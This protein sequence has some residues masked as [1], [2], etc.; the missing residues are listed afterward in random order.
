MPPELSPALLH[1]ELGRAYLDWIDTAFA[2]NDSGVMKER[3]SLLGERGKLVADVYF[4]AIKK[5]QAG[6]SFA[7]VVAEIGL[8]EE[9]GQLLEKA[10]LPPGGTLYPHQVRAIQEF[11]TNG[12]CPIVV[13]GTGSGKTE[14]FLLPLIASILLEHQKAGVAAPPINRWWQENGIRQAG[15]PRAKAHNGHS[16]TMRALI[17]YPTNA[18]VEDQVSRLRRAVRQLVDPS[19]GAPLVWFGR[20]TGEQVDEKGNRPPGDKGDRA[21]EN[22]LKVKLR[23]YERD[24]AEAEQRA[25][26]SPELRS[27]LDY[28]PNPLSGELLSRLDIREAPPD[29]LVTNHSMLNVMLMRN[30][31]DSVFESTRDWLKEDSTHKFTLIVDELHLHRGSAGAEVGLVIRNLLR[32]IGLRSDSSQF[33]VIATS[34]SLGGTDETKTFARRFFGVS[35]SRFEVVDGAPI[36]LV[37]P[38]KLLANNVIDLVKGNQVSGESIAAYVELAGQLPSETIASS[39]STAVMSDRDLAGKLFPGAPSGI[40][41][42]AFE[43]LL[44]LATNEHANKLD[45]YESA[46]IRSHIFVRL[47]AGLWACSSPTCSSVSE[48]YRSSSRKIGRLY[49]SPRISCVGECSARVLELLYCEQ[50]GDISLGGFVADH[51]GKPSEGLNRTLAP[52]S[53][54]DS[55]EVDISP[56]SRSV[57]QYSWYRPGVSGEIKKKVGGYEMMLLP[58]TFDPGA[59]MLI[60]DESLKTTGMSWIPVRNNSTSE[61]LLGRLPSFPG[62][63]PAC[64]SNLESS[65]SKLDVER[66]EIRTSVRSHTAGKPTTVALLVDR[67][68]ALVEESAARR[69]IVFSDSRT[70]AAR[71]SSV[72]SRNQFQSLV[73][74]LIGKIGKRFSPLSA[75]SVIEILNAEARAKLDES[76]RALFERIHQTDDGKALYILV[77]RKAFEDLAP[78]EESEIQR[79]LPRLEAELGGGIKWSQLIDELTSELVA[80][81]VCPGG[82]EASYLSLREGHPA[83]DWF[84]AYKPLRSFER[85]SDRTPPMDDAERK[86]RERA[87]RRLAEWVAD[88]SFNRQGR[89]IEYARAGHLTVR[90]STDVPVSWLKGMQSDVAASVLRIL[91]NTGRLQRRDRRVYTQAS[92]LTPAA[93]DYLERV[94][95]RGGSTDVVDELE[96]LSNWVSDQISRLLVNNNLN[97]SEDIDGWQVSLRPSSAKIYICDSCNKVHAHESA[98]VCTRIRCAG[99]LKPQDGHTRVDYWYESSKYT[100][101]KVTVK[102][103]TGTTNLADQKRRARLFQGL[104]FSTESNLASPVDVL[105]ATTTLEMGVDVGG[106][107]VVVNSVMPPARYNYQQRVGRAG[108]RLDSVFSTAITVAGNR[109]NDDHYYANPLPMLQGVPPAPFLDV[110]RIRIVQRV[111]NAESLRMAFQSTSNPPAWNPQD[112]HGSFGSIEEWKSY[113][114]EVRGFFENTMALSKIVEELTVNTEISNTQASSIMESLAVV[115]EKI[116]SIVGEELLLDGQRRTSAVLAN[117]GLLPMFGFPTN[118]RNLWIPSSERTRTAMESWESRNLD[119]ALGEFAPGQ[120]RIRDGK[121]ATAIG[122]GN[123]SHNLPRKPLPA[124]GPEQR[125]VSCEECGETRADR[126]ID[127]EALVG[128]CAECGGSLRLT[129][130]VEP[131]G[132]VAASPFDFDDGDDDYVSVSPTKLASPVTKEASVEVLGVWIASL[133]QASLVRINDNLGETYSL[134]KSKS[135]A[136][137]DALVHDDLNVYRNQN[138][139]ELVKGIAGGP[140][141]V[142][143]D[144]PGAVI[145]QNKIGDV[146]LFWF[147]QTGNPQTFLPGGT[148][149]TSSKDDSSGKAALWSFGELLRRGA[150]DRF[151]IAPGEW[152]LGLTGSKIGGTYSSRIFLADTLANGA[153]FATE[154]TNPETFKE[155]LQYLRDYTLPKM[156]E[157]KH[158]LECDSSCPSCLR[159]YETRRVHGLLNWRLAADLV[160][161][162][163]GDTP[164]LATWTEGALQLARGIQSQGGQSAEV[165]V[166][167]VDDVVYMKHQ[168]KVLAIGHPV[169]SRDPRHFTELQAKIAQSIHDKLKA[170]VEWTDT[171]EIARFPLRVTVRL[172]ANGEQG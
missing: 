92:V 94:V 102:E 110:S 32:R 54:T 60:Q 161:I 85:S 56:N 106:L 10:L 29:I 96:A 126:S 121:I 167:V 27:L 38:R 113:A 26:E 123:Y 108:R 58:V 160:S 166:G 8:N 153:G 47:L 79:L 93:K 91:A 152:E 46:R 13:T 116:D 127:P 43:A 25:A 156:R 35:E 148:I 114:A 139:K 86:Y 36:E 74:N 78:D 140:Y 128:A 19:T 75:L 131:Q 124:L 97:P 154:I 149:R 23:E 66:G 84:N 141:G 144:G 115:P 157:S 151:D 4:E 31:E 40:A 155:L 16:A 170:T 71:V 30:K 83:E 95:R 1:R 44:F 120:E 165:A 162:A 169:W 18:L 33:Q 39:V 125:L 147:D 119:I 57:G 164:S 133:E 107:R 49:S 129:T 89:D 17:L 28:L 37:G 48:E 64:E 11:I 53:S 99:I 134:R 3:R 24:Y 72:L 34:A 150:Q 61:D 138:V 52:S 50:C 20:F 142:N 62:V 65:N 132:F 109:F 172:L 159:G 105:S 146:A 88:V 103:L 70:D 80:L 122:F 111:I 77:R 73:K 90:T 21:D 171:V 100:P 117:R 59:G 168:D 5:Y 2:L 45:G 130:F 158:Q 63:C 55:S 42:D 98:G 41:D 76:Q 112:T 82:P 14:S 15:G 135:P 9:Y 12:K 104:T 137:P 51:G 69:V 136:Y 7:S 22:Y 101:R 145:G 6:E 87:R 68:A 143:K 163:S 81:G 118:I 67:I